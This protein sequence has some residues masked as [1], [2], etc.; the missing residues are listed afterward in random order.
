MKIYNNGGNQ[1]DVARTLKVTD[2]TVSLRIKHLL[3]IG[4]NLPKMKRT[5]NYDAKYLNKIIANYS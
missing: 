3:N 1:A 5:K 4:V 2:A